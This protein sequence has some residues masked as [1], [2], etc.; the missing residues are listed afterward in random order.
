MVTVQIYGT[1]K[2][3]EVKD[4]NIT[5]VKTAGDLG[6]LT[7]I[8]SSY[9]W[10]MKFPKTENNTQV[11]DGLGLVGSGS[12]KP[13]EKIYCNL[14]DNGFPIVIKGLLNIKETA[15]DYGVFV[16][17]GFIDFIKDI[18]NDTVGEDLDLSPLDHTRDYTTIVNSF[19]LNLPYAYLVADV[20]GGYLLNESNTTNLDPNYMAPY[21]NVGY[22]WDLIFSTYGW[23]FSLNNEVRESIDGTWMSYPSEIVFGDEDATLAGDLSTENESGIPLGVGSQAHFFSIPFDTISLDSDYVIPLNTSGREFVIQENGN[24]KLSYDSE[25]T[26]NI[27]DRYG[28]PT[29][30]TYITVIYVN[31]VRING[32]SGSKSDVSQTTDYYI[33]LNEGDVIG[34]V[35]YAQVISTGGGDTEVSIDSAFMEINYLVQGEVS[36]TQALIK[37]KISDFIKEVMT[38]EALT[39]FVDSENRHIDFL[40][41]TERVN[42]EVED[43]SHLYSKRLSETYLY[44][45]YAQNNYLRHKYNNENEDFNDGLL[46]IDNLNLDNEKTIY[47]SNSFSPSQQLSTFTDSGDEYKVPILQMFDAEVKD[48]AGVITIEYKFLKD[49]F[50]FVKHVQS[51]RDIYIDTNLVEG[52]PMVSVSGATYRDIVASKYQSFTKMAND[53]KVHR[54]ELAMPLVDIVSL[55]LRKIKYIKDQASYYILNKL[56]YKKGQKSIG[57]FLK[58]EPELSGGTGAFSNAFDNSFSI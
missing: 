14:L 9:S 26:V 24:Y 20:N 41:L 22:L 30:G 36:F 47:P 49:R 33:Q 55:D 50:F 56:T 45:D 32:S 31:G 15:E 2:K 5:Y 6:E 1:D 57:E 8:N 34:L 17:E 28:N 11:L 40:T 29:M 44:Q 54:I 52:F 46:T 51:S 4:A 48:E 42:Y 27:E 35:A 25:G 39:P 18:A 3:L 53:A 21:A 10:S 37:F 7:S 12:R 58:V 23:T 19:A 13:Y 38:R 16:Q 43:W